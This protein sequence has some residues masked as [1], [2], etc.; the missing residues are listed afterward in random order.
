MEYAVASNPVLVSPEYW[1]GTNVDDPEAYNGEA[2]E[3]LRLSHKQYLTAA[4][5]LAY[6]LQ[7]AMADQVIETPTSESDLLARVEISP[8]QAQVMVINTEFLIRWDVD[9][10][11]D[12]ARVE[13]RL[14]EGH[15]DWPAIERPF[16]NYWL[17]HQTTLPTRERPFVGEEH[18]AFPSEQAFYYHALQW[19]VLTKR[20]KDGVPVLA[21]WEFRDARLMPNGKIQVPTGSHRTSSLSLSVGEIVPDEPLD[22]AYSPRSM[23]RV[24]DLTAIDITPAGYAGF[25]S[26]YGRQRELQ[27]V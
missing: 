8:I 18:A 5:L 7:N 22:E 6:T 26:P 15:T 25:D 19:A 21:M 27:Y 16:T 13:N 20:Q 11:A 9:R 12:Q 24:I 23:H 10:P 3:H 4:G 14:M 1:G 17:K 2:K